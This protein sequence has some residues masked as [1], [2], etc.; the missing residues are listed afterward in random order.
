MV[1]I[2]RAMI[3]PAAVF[4]QPNEVVEHPQLAREQQIEI[5]RLWHMMPA[6]WQWWRKKM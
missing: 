1:D 2:N 5:L 6:P 3:N 4:Q